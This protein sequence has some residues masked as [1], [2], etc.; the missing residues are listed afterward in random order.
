M[1]AL[2]TR[3][4]E[5][6]VHT[7]ARSFIRQLT[8]GPA[9]APHAVAAHSEALAAAIAVARE[10]TSVRLLLDYDGTLVPLA[11]SPELAEPDPDLV[12]LLEVLAR[13]PRLAVE[14]VSGRPRDTLDRWFGHLPIQLWAEHGFWRRRPP[15]EEWRP[16][17]EVAPGWKDRIHP[18]LEQFTTSTPGSF[19]E[20]KT[21][22]VAWH[23]RGADPEF[24]ARQAHELRMLLGDALSNQP[25]EVLEGKKVIEVRFRA[26]S[27]AVV[28]HR[29]DTDAR[30]ST[31]VVFGDDRTDEDLFRALPD[32]S[33]T[34]AVGQRLAGAR[35]QVDG[36]LTV[37]EILRAVIAVAEKTEGREKAEDRITTEERS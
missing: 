25:L 18:I 24:G 4:L 14:I 10:T 36:H 5:Y 31:V 1:R 8:S 15:R 37:R 35:W 23:Y 27:K 20:V 34:V 22:S 33:I 30:T 6:D 19:I 12:R 17:A 7:W 16:A 13:V 32:S 28:A 11:R 2:R 3:V 26:I 9:A 21:A 29:T